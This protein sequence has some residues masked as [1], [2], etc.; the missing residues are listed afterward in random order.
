MMT[1]LLQSG[2]HLL[3]PLGLLARGLA[4][5]LSLMLLPG[6]GGWCHHTCMQYQKQMHGDMSRL[7]CAAGA[8]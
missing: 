4:L 8:A 7:W 5:L 2:E 3:P 6:R 1:L